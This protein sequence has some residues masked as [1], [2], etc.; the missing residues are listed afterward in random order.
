MI[1]IA[2][3]VTQVICLMGAMEIARIVILHVKLAM[4]INLLIAR[5]VKVECILLLEVSAKESRIL[6]VALMIPT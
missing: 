2:Q 5:V 3:V 4:E 1:L 6:H